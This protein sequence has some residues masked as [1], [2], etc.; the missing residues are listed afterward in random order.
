MTE[1]GITTGAP[2]GGA[3]PGPD[4]RVRV[5]E[6]LEVQARSLRRLALQRFVRHKP[7]MVSLVLLVLIGL[8]VAFPDPLID[9]APGD[10]FDR[11]LRLRQHPP[12]A[13]AWL[14]TDQLGR[15]YFSRTLLATRTSV[16]A[17]LIVALVSTVVGSVV[18]LLAG[19]R[20]GWVD[21]VLMRLVDLLLAIPFLALLLTVSAFTGWRDPTLVGLVIAGLVWVTIAR[22]VRGNVLSLRE[23][24]FVEAARASGASD[25]RVMFRHILPN[26]MSP[27]IVNATLIIAIAIL[28]EAAL[29]FL[30]FGIERPFPALGKMVNDHQRF[31]MSDW[32]LVWV[33]GLMI[34]VVCLCVNFIGDGLR[35]ALDPT[36]QRR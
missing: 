4:D 32:W 15:D 25:V 35:D 5:R 7:A 6:G 2:P 21:N 23:K 29:S 22:V 12:S 36:L 34:M 28:L 9:A 30:G 19:Y 24:E 3:D 31:M 27:I 18:G 1:R 33:P 13:D 20:R 26:T 17:A 11:D 8:A 16:S 10:P 14:G